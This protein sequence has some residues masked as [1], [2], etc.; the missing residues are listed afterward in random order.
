MVDECVGIAH[1]C[2]QDLQ[3][4]PTNFTTKCSHDENLIRD[5]I[6]HRKVQHPKKLRFHN[7]SHKQLKRRVLSYIFLGVLRNET[8]PVRMNCCHNRDAS[9]QDVKQ[10][11]ESA[12]GIAQKSVHRRL[13]QNGCEEGK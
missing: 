5:E 4:A 2:L 9:D 11:G 12:V 13:M 3:T 10:R 6:K 8:C 7:R 1:I